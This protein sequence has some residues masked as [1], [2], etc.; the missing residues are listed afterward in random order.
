L[1]DYLNS[2]RVKHRGSPETH[3]SQAQA[4]LD[5]LHGLATR[6][7]ESVLEKHQILQSLEFSI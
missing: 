5:A 1:G 2:I 3:L 7:G 6:L 4:K